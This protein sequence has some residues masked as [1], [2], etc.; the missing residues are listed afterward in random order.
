M[1]LQETWFN[2]D[3][4]PTF[5][6]YSLFCINRVG[7]AGGGVAILVRSDLVAVHIQ[8]APFLGGPAKCEIQCIEIKA[9]QTVVRIMNLYNPNEVVT[10]EEFHHYFSQAGPKFIIVGDFNAHHPVWSRRVRRPCRTGNNLME[11]VMRLPM[12][13]L[14]SQSMPTYLDPRTGQASTLDL[15]FVSVNLF[16]QSYIELGEDLGSDHCSIFV[17]I[18]CAPAQVLQK[19]RPK[20]LLKNKDTSL[21]PAALPHLPEEV[22]HL[23][24]CGMNS[25]LSNTLFQTGVKV[26]GRSRSIVNPQYCKSWWNPECAHKVAFRKRAFRRLRDHPTPVNV[27]L[28]REAQN[29]AKDAV[30]ELKK[31]SVKDYCSSIN[32]QSPLG[33]VWKKINSLR[34]PFQHSNSSLLHNDV[35]VTCSEEQANLFAQHFE[36]IYKQPL[37]PAAAAV[38]VPASAPRQG[39]PYNQYFQMSELD[40]VLQ[41][42][43]G[44]SPGIDNIHNL[45]LKSLPEEYSQFMLRMFNKIWDSGMQPDIWKKAL[46]VPILKFGKSDRLVTSYRPISLLSCIGKV[47]ERMV[48]NRLYWVLENNSQL[49]PSQ[50]GFRKR[51]N[52]SD[53]VARLEKIIME[54]YLERKVCLAVFLDLKSAYDTVGHPALLAKLSR[55]GIQG[56]LFTWVQDFL[57]NRSFQ[58]LH[59]GEQSEAKVFKTGVPQGSSISPLLFNVFVADMPSFP[60][61]LR[62]EYADDAALVCQG[63]TMAEATELM[64]RALNQYH[65]FVHANGLSINY[66]KTVAM[67]FTRK[68]V[69]PLPLNINLCPVEFVQSFKYLGVTFNGPVLDW[70]VHIAKLRV[71]CS[72]RCNVLKAVSSQRWGADRAMLLQMYRALVL[73]K[74]SFGAEF[75]STACDTVLKTLDPIQ[76]LALQLCIGA[77][78]T[79]PTCSLEVEA[80]I[81]PLSLQRDTLVLEFYNRVRHLPS[82]LLLVQELL[83][84]VALQATLAWSPTMRP[85]VIVRAYQ[86]MMSQNNILDVNP[87]PL[88]GITPPWTVL[89]GVHGFMEDEQVKSAS[90]GS[91]QQ[92][93]RSMCQEKYP[94]SIHIYTDGSKYTEVGSEVVGAAMVVP[95]IG[96]VDKW[97]LP[98]FLSILSAELFAIWM[99]L[100]WIVEQQDD[101]EYIILTDSLSSVSLLRN[102]QNSGKGV[103]RHMILE[104]LSQLNEIS[105]RVSIL[106]I[107]SHRGIP[108][109]E[110]ADKAAKEAT[111][112]RVIALPHLT[113]KDGKAIFRKWMF[114]KWK[115]RW[116][117][118]R[119]TSGIGRHLFTIKKE[120]AFWPWSLLP[121]NRELESALA[122]LRIGHAGLRCHLFRFGLYWSPLCDCG[123]PETVEHYFLHC[124][125]YLAPRALLRRAAR[126]VGVDFSL[127]GLLGGGPIDAAEQR[128][129]IEAV[130]LFLTSTGKMSTV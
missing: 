102:D 1:C 43:V 75:Y 35:L 11:T 4:L 106:W 109:N 71:D 112:E 113:R 2:N 61:V 66:Q 78:K 92:L 104:L 30:A 56:R 55:M 19:R 20:W 88:V 82:Q 127:Q 83:L 121:Q 46:L 63:T 89:S 110:S 90:D 97:K 14:T 23:D 26:F 57:S 80:H 51:L 39:Q 103:Y 58:V 42:L 98:H 40:R 32:S 29:N 10:P 72:K 12:Q 126:R 101:S 64:Q 36:Q 95:E 115:T 41:Y 38:A 91:V 99:S 120:I 16:H 45:F 73:S 33:Q 114:A 116:E 69:L 48:K 50:S 52:T 9:R 119:Q 76:N 31:Q 15:C 17:T 6:N 28:H 128:S 96:H 54:T 129:M 62:M 77:R 84:T 105:P 107:P 130:S 7:R 21:F 18:A 53:Q 79:S 124:G 59:N 5:Y 74:L 81:P 87:Y 37:A 94:F 25:W 22:S 67:L 24:G 123:Q 60:G 85:P 47:M 122:R 34:T 68:K 3:Y 49:C 70:K 44:S 86:M 111:T 100:K 27:H 108:G 8:L 118:A 117:A 93:F 125:N 13:L 65:A